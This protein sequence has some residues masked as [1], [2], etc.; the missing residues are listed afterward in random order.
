MKD[1]WVAIEDRDTC[2]ISEFEEAEEKD[3][4]YLMAGYRADLCHPA[5]V[6]VRDTDTESGHNVVYDGV[7]YRGE[8]GYNLWVMH[9]Y[10]ED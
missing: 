10:E 5:Q 9:K 3:V 6:R 8:F 4:Q 7:I 2:E 1:Y